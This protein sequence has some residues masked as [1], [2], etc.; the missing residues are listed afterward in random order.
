MSY[1]VSLLSMCK[2]LRDENSCDN[3]FKAVVVQC[4]VFVK[5]AAH[6]CLAETDSGICTWT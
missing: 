2:K 5:K 1:F 6:K 4:K 3:L